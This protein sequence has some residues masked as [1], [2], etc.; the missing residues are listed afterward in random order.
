MKKTILSILVIFAVF[1]ALQGC[2]GTIEYSL[3]LRP[4]GAVMERTVEIPVDLEKFKRVADLYG[5]VPSDDELASFTSDDAVEWYEF[6][7]SFEHTLPDDIGGEGFL[8]HFAS[9]LGISSIYTERL[10]GVSDLSRIFE[11]RRT[12]FDR[13]WSI[14]LLWLDHM[15]SDA[16]DYQ[17]L[18]QF[19]DTTLRQDAW[20]ILLLASSTDTLA[21]TMMPDD[22]GFEEE[23]GL[24]VGMRILHYLIERN[25]IEGASLQDT[26]RLFAASET[27]SDEDF[28]VYVQFVAESIARVMNGESGGELP[29]PLAKLASFTEEQFEATGDTFLD[30]NTALQ[31][32]IAEWNAAADGLGPYELESDRLGDKLLIQ[33]L[34]F[35]V[36]L[37]G[38]DGPVIQIELHLTTRPYATNGIWNDGVVSW[39]EQLSSEDPVDA[40]LPNVVYAMW[41]EPDAGYQAER[42]GLLVFDDERLRDHVLWRAGLSEKRRLEWDE[43]VETLRPDENIFPALRAFSFS[44]ERPHPTQSNGLLSRVAQQPLLAIRKAVASGPQ[45]CPEVHCIFE[46]GSGWQRSTAPEEVK[47]LLQESAPYVEAES[48]EWFDRDDGTVLGCIAFDAARPLNAAHYLFPLAD[49]QR[50]AP[51]KLG[52]TDLCESY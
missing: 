10:G 5:I 34:G 1:P 42:F 9:P 11:I 27:A 36:D 13:Y 24:P 23:F 48:V 16:K 18:R 39:D 26:I 4:R 2:R 44:D 7:G 37:F 32:L 40:D 45:F 8:I 31:E 35:S 25:Y 43:F 22:Y 46:N 41:S 28:D 21:R 33:L 14:V 47:R 6:S 51:S 20:N 12:V 50:S 38:Y 17:G 52:V 29:A 30:D 19:A 3:Q 49:G 15:L